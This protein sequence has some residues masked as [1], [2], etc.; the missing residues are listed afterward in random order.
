MEVP[1]FS[2]S[3]LLGADV[4]LGVEMASTGEVACFG[5]DVYE[6]FLLAQEAALL[7]IREGRLPAPG[8]NILLS[9]GAYRHKVFLLP[10]VVKLAQLGYHLY[11]SRGTADYYSTQGLDIITVEW[12]YEDYGQKWLVLQNLLLSP[13]IETRTIYIC[14]GCLTLFSQLGHIG[15]KT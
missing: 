9:I 7:N 15:R 10:S 1:V 14:R 6:A 13:Q 4:L 8:A 2:F 11:G 12:P 5:R 3:R